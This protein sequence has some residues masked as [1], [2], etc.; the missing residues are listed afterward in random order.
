MLQML[1]ETDNGPIDGALVSLNGYWRL[2]S[3][4]RRAGFDNIL[5]QSY[6]MELSD[7]LILLQE[8]GWEVKT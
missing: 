3:I 8:Q 1:K 6:G 7:L 2:I 5:V 4:E